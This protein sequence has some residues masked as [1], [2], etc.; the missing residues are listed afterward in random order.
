MRKT[1]G[2]IKHHWRPVYNQSASGTT[3]SS[4]FVTVLNLTATKRGKIA[5][6]SANYDW[7][8][9]EMYVEVLIDGVTTLIYRLTGNATTFRGNFHFN[10]S[11]RVRHK[12]VT[13][14]RNMRTEIAYW[15]I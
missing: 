12:H 8:A 2:G 7:M 13:S 6:F 14:A 11:I 9:S 10:K 1:L 15:V 5:I 4:S 3:G